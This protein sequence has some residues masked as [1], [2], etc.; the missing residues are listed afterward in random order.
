MHDYLYWD[1]SCTRAQADQIFLLAMIEN[2]VGAVHQKALHAAVSIA[3]SFAS[4]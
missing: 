1:Q 2:K 4:G 3:G